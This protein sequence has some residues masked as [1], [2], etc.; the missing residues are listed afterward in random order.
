MKKL[1]KDFKNSIERVTS[2]SSDRKEGLKMSISKDMLELSVNSPNSGEGTEN[3]D[4]NFNSDNGFNRSPFP[5][6]N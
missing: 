4:A 6:I 5:L 1:Q 2:V 3:I